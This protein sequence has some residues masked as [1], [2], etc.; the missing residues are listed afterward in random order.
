MAAVIWLAQGQRAAMQSRRR[1]PPRTMRPA[2]EKVGS[3]SFL[4]SDPAG[5]AR[6]GEHLDPCEQ[7]A[8]QRDDLDPDHVP[9]LAVPGGRLRGRCHSAADPVLAPGSAQVA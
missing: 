2:A 5:G 8:G 6:Q 3:R 4:G 1:R 7:F 9:V